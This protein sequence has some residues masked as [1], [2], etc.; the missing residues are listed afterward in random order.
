MNSLL[1]DIAEN[2]VPTQA[3]LARIYAAEKNF[4]LD[5]AFWQTVMN[6]H[7]IWKR[8]GSTFEIVT[9]RRQPIF[10]GSVHSSQ[11]SVE[12]GAIEKKSYK[13]F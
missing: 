10:K 5:P 3:D 11:K 13:I 4:Q 1:L 6:T 8:N 9:R 2:F 7:L 12:I